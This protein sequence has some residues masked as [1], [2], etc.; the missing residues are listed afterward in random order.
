MA[1]FKWDHVHLRSPD[2]EATAAFYERMFGAEVV[3]TMPQ[4]KPRIV[5]RSA[6]PACSSRR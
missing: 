2:P 5:S 4:G 3:R 1:S 6:A